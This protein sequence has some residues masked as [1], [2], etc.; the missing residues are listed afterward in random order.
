MILDKLKQ[1]KLLAIS[2]EAL[3][4]SQELRK[5]KKGCEQT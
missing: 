1:I 5:G 4:N 3:E 2:G